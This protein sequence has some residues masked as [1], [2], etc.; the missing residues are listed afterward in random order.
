[1]RIQKILSIRDLSNGMVEITYKLTSPVTSDVLNILSQG[2]PVITGYQYLSPT[3]SISKA[4][5]TLL[6][7]IIKSPTIQIRCTSESQTY[8]SDYIDALLSTIQD[9]ISTWSLLYEIMSKIHSLIS[10][11]KEKKKYE[12]KEFIAR[13]L[14]VD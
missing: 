10:K 7:G 8:L 3:Y 5:G 6:S 12:D 4:D 14:I 11:R 1:M 13:E 9:T 2:E